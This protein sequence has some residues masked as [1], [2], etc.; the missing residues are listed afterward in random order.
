MIALTI[1][2]MTPHDLETV[3]AVFACWHKTRDL[4]QFYLA[5]QAQN[6]R[7]VLLALLGE[8]V[9]GYTTLDW[10][11]QDIQFALRGIPEIVDLNVH[12]DY[13]RRGIGTALIRA[14]EALA[15][16][17][18]YARIG[19]GVELHPQYAAAQRLYPQLGYV[20]LEGESAPDEWALVKAL[21]P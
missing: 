18:G 7:V 10:I 11:S 2:Q 12:P 20:P 9:A 21:T 13:Q 16:E 1:R 5:E 15:R 4:F 6:A 14:C 17:R 8:Q 3:M 19:I